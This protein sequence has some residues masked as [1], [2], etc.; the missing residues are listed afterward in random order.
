[1]RLLSRS[2]ASAATSFV[3]IVALVALSALLVPARSSGATA[4]R[5]AVSASSLQSA[6]DAA[7]AATKIPGV[8]AAVVVDGTVAWTG[9]SGLAVDRTGLDAVTGRPAVRRSVPLTTATRFSIAS[10][11]KT[12]TATMV[13]KL[14]QDGR[15]GLDDPVAQWVTPAPPG[16][17]RVT[18]RELL[19]H[20]SGYPDVETYGELADQ[21]DLFTDYDPGRV[22]DLPHILAAMRAPR[23]PPGSRYEYSNV[24]YLLLGAILLRAGGGTLDGRLHAM[25]ADPLGLT[26]TSYADQPGLARRM[27]HGYETYGRKRYDH[28]SG[29]TTT[30]TDLVGPVWADG[31][32]VTT[33]ADAA[34]F[35][36]ALA[37][38]KIL[39][40][41]TLATML[42]PST[43]SGSE[44][45]G[46]A[47]YVL[48]DAG[49]TWNGHDGNYAG[50]QTVMF[51]DAASGLTVAVFA[52]D[53]SDGVW[54]VFSALAKTLRP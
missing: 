4:A 33:A 50:Y 24:N 17:D 19:N 54:D 26:Q 38:G 2:S 22:Y 21:L 39:D 11:S 32:V 13:L 51:S 36:N 30:P 34:R 20:T 8:Q 43:V 31:G 35:G 52:N 15:I 37:L 1:M 18:V 6:L 12:Y 14:V 16:G 23:F 53:D 44:R 27:A 46:M 48:E 47:S 10:L 28:W 5:P 29:S 7:R 41:P 3:A 49:R 40:P 42:T 45:Y 9:A 25:I